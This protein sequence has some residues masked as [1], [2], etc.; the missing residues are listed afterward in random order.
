MALVPRQPVPP[1]VVETVD[2]RTFDLRSANAEKFVLI[3]VYRGL[4]CPL[5]RAYL[6]ELASLLP[7]FEKRGVECL[8]ISTDDRERTAAMAG[9][10]GSSTLRF[11]AALPLAS[12][13]DWGLYISQG[14]GKTSI[15][16]EEPALFAE[17]GVFIVRPD[18]TLYYANVQTM[19]FARP[20]FKELLMAI[21]YAITKDYPSR[22]EYTGP[23]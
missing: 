15:G 6:A 20:Q 11:G 7:E 21:D 1:L 16:I 19:P 22:G 3:V 17:P 13:R 4:H 23:V 9:K 12:A 14:R 10:V 2:N 8:A 18:S 5:C